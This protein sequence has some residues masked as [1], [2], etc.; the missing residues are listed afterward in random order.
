MAAKIN[1]VDKAVNILN[2]FTSQEPVRTVGAISKS[3]GYTLSTVS[4]LLSTLEARGVVQKLKGHGRYQL[5]PRIYLWGQLCQAQNHLAA[6]ALPAME[7]LR[8]RCGEEVS[9][10]IA[11]DGARSCLER[12][13]SRHAIAMTGDVG[14]RLPLHAGAA[15]RVLLAFMDDKNCREYIE[16]M[17]LERFTEN[18][19]T[20]VRKLDAEL[21]EIRRLDWALSREERE[22][23][24]YSVVA[25][26]R[27][28]SGRVVASLCIAGPLYRL[29]DDLAQAYLTD[30]R[31][32][33]AEISEKMGYSAQT[34]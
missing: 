13:P 24:S 25:P 15:G 23:G 1:S 12:V 20:D 33:A 29:T 4:R 5:G 8:D 10:H 30:V 2:C 18:T 11:I 21:K 16:K 6:A 28:A 32:T 22:P 17:G 19:L 34:L 7:A 26:V 14:G 3:T 27:E 9:L 31:S